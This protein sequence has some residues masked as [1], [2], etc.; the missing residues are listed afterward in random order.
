LGTI[1]V[2]SP[3][4][5]FSSIPHPVTLQLLVFDS[6]FS[7]FSGRTFPFFVLKNLPVTLTSSRDLA[8]VGVIDSI[9]GGVILN[10]WE[11][12]ID[13]LSAKTTAKSQTSGDRVMTEKFSQKDFLPN[14]RGHFFL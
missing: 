4:P 1:N 11:N 7:T 2:I 9:W 13:D 6:P 3:C 5:V 14:L 12:V 8:F 10:P